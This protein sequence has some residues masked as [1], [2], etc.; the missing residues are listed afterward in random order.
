[1]NI[2]NYFWG[3]TF[4][5]K[6]TL[7]VETM[8]RLGNFNWDERPSEVEIAYFL[9]QMGFRVE[10]FSTDE[11]GDADLFLTDLAGHMKKHGYTPHPRVDMTL[12]QDI[13]RK[14]VTHPEYILT[15]DPSLDLEQIIRERSDGKHMFLF[16]LDGDHLYREEYPSRDDEAPGHIMASFGYAGDDERLTL[17]ETSPCG[18]YVYRTYDALLESMRSISGNG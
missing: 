5:T 17:I 7:D 3:T 6:D 4:N 10:F 13:L 1:M 11:P 16:G 12:S 9:L 2:L 15:E 8:I 18:H 14:A